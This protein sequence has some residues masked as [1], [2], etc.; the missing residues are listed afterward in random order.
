[1]RTPPAH[2]TR[3][4]NLL[5]KLAGVLA[6]AHLILVLCSALTIPTLSLRHLPGKLSFV[7]GKWSGALSRFS[8][9]APNVA[10]P[11]RVVCEVVLDSGERV[12]DNLDFDNEALKIRAY[13]MSLRFNGNHSKDD[14]K[15]DMARAWAALMF[16]RHPDAHALTVRMERMRVPSM[17]QYRAG[18]R[19]SWYETYR[20]DFELRPSPS[21]AQASNP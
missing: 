15:D 21:A 5:F 20:A 17:E 6:A 19:P 3:K 8:F 11:M 10:P 4:R 1:M 14:T 9:F 13:A 2:P 12:T 16:G 18:E 7:Y